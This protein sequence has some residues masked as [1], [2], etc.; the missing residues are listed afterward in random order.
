MKFSKILGLKPE[1]KVDALY[2]R[3]IDTL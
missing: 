2:K 1:V 3:I